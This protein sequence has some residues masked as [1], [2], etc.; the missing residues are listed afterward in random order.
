MMRLLLFL[1]LF[2]FKTLSLEFTPQ[3]LFSD[4]IYIDTRYPNNDKR[5]FML[6]HPH[7]HIEQQEF[8]A[9]LIFHGEG[10]NYEEVAAITG[11][12][13]SIPANGLFAIFL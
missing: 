10:S 9:V 8:P 7:N 6:N 3:P 5:F 13:K 2:M 4:K 12:W 1:I 11:F